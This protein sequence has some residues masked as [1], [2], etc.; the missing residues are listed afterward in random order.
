MKVHKPFNW[1]PYIVQTGVGDVP[2]KV[3]RQN[4]W[5][6]YIVQTGGGRIL[7]NICR[8]SNWNLDI[9][10]TGVGGVPMK[11]H[12]Q[13]NW[14]QGFVQTGGGVFQRAYIDKITGH[15]PYRGGGVGLAWEGGGGSARGILKFLSSCLVRI[16]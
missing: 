11:V 14:N 15:C 2:M 6:P 5:N 13:S 7:M 3:H 8:K 10:E 16:A 12:R 9:V 4:S 1:N